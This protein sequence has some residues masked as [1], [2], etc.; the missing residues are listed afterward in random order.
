MKHLSKLLSIALALALCSGCGAQAA[1]TL[2]PITQTSAVAAEPQTA[3]IPEAPAESTSTVNVNPDMFTD[4]D[5]ETDY[6]DYVT[7][8]LSDSGSSADGG[9]VSI[10]GSVITI[11]EDGTYRLTGTLTN[12]QIVVELPD[13]AK[14]QLVLDNASVTCEGSA[15]LYVK[16]GDKLF[17][18]TTAGSENTLASAGE[19]AQNDDKVDGAVFSRIDLTM[20][21]LGTLTV[22]SQAGHGVVAKDDLKVTCGSYVIEAAKDGFDANDSVRIAGGSMVIRS[23]DDGMQAETDDP[24]DGYIYIAGGSITIECDHDGIQASST[25]TVEG[26]SI[27]ILAGGGK[28]NAPEKTN[29]WNARDFGSFE[30]E[31]AWEES[32]DESGESDSA[33]GLKAE[34]GVK[35][36]GGSVMLDTADDGIHANGDVTVSGGT[37]SIASGDDG[38]HADNAL[39]ISG[40]VLDIEAYEGLEGLSITLE[41]GEITITAGDDGINASGGS[42]TL[43]I[44]GG[45]LYLKS[46]GDTL[47]S[48][49]TM[50][51]TGGE[52]YITGPQGTGDGMLDYD[53][54]GSIS[55]GLV[56][57]TG[58]AGMQ[59]NFDQSSTQGSIL[60]TLSA[61]QPA[62]TAVTLTDESGSVIAEYTAAEP[63]QVVLISAPEITA[64]QTYTLTVGSETVPIEMTSLLYGA[65]NGFGGGGGFGGFGGRRG[66]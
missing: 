1:E 59:A 6:A 27:D 61:S 18:T 16:T 7:V 15:A 35:V 4:R 54:G 43:L 17:I 34:L 66:I 44:S 57:G 50:L 8:T 48:N 60:Y 31:N 62:G 46:S 10:D 32:Q 37:I 51:I 58:V 22:S 21:G 52:I 42:A 2:E 28:A 19:Y 24:E 5:Y 29:Y 56:I 26:G 9:G 3:D 47:D 39:T 13:D 53:F 41:D 55:G 11:T 63:F 20:N 64:G 30:T 14:T 49:G 36:S 38:I 23:G 40:G 25:V 45:V 65:G 12:G 33:K